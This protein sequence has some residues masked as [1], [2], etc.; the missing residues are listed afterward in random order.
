MDSH[1]PHTSV[2]IFHP[3]KALNGHAISLVSKL[4]EGFFFVFFPPVAWLL[5]LGS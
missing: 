3:S 1:S 5:P 4:H 2:T